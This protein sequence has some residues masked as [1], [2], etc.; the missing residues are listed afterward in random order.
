MNKESGTKLSEDTP[1]FYVSLTTKINIG[2]YESND[3]S[4]GISN[5]PVNCTA[6]Y[7]QEVL[8]AAIARTQ[9]SLDAMAAEMGRILKEDYGR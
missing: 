8:Q 1:K 4:F 2:N 6:E 7:L 3:V 9:V 5:I